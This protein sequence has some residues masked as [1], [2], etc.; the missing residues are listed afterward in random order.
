MK[1]SLF[2]YFVILFALLVFFISCKKDQ[3]TQ[4]Y[5]YA[6]IDSRLQ[7]FC[8]AKGSYW[9]YQK[10]TSNQFDS[11]IAIGGSTSF[12][13]YYH[14]LNYHTMIEYR[15]ISYKEYFSTGKI[16]SFS[17]CLIGMN[18]DRNFI[19]AYPWPFESVLF[20]FDTTY[21]DHLDSLIVNNVIYY[22]VQKSDIQNNVF[23]TVPGFGL[24]RFLLLDSGKFSKWD[25][26]KSNIIFDN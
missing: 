13:D 9:I 6:Y 22:D 24:I 16:N 14:G 3:A 12:Y 7:D 15:R 1:F 10:D 21:Y 8:F 4:Q 18:L 11:I 5:T 25:L 23:Y 26:V 19:P 17:D 20:S 2:R